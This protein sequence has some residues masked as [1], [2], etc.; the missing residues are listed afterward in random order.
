[1]RGNKG[2]PT[3][4]NSVL[5]TLSPPYPLLEYLELSSTSWV[6]HLLIPLK[7]LMDL[8]PL[9]S[10]P[11]EPWMWS[12]EQMKELLSRNLEASEE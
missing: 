4:E 2:V 10:P 12:P 1:M 11:A 8:P 5:A 6:F 7:H 3:A 9:D